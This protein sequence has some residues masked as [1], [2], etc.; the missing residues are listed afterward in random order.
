MLLLYIENGAFSFGN[1]VFLETGVV[2]AGGVG[3]NGN[4][5]VKFLGDA[6]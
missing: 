5:R 4:G 1:I 3:L 2:A 6:V